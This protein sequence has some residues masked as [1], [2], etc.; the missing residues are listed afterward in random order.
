MLPL[1][2]LVIRPNGTIDEVDVGRPFQR[3]FGTVFIKHDEKTA[4]V[5]L[6]Q[7]DAVISI[8]LEGPINAQALPHKIAGELQ[9]QDINFFT[10]VPGTP[11]VLASCRYE[12]VALVN[13][14]TLTTERRYTVDIFDGSGAVASV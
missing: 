5:V 6:D 10:D 14:R 2:V 9:L 11:Y 1:P 4:L 3:G 8:P 13:V 12:G 7:S